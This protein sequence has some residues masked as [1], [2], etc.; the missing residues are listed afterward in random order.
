MTWRTPASLKWLIVQRSRLSGAL[1]QIDNQKRKL[2]KRLD[3]L[4]NRAEALREQLS[5]L[6][7]TFGLH[8]IRVDPKC[9]QPV[10]PQ[11]KERL[12]PPGRLGRVI[13]AELRRADDWLSSTE[14]LARIANHITADGLTYFEVRHRLRRRLGRLGRDGILERQVRY[15]GNGANDD[16]LWRIA[17]A[18]K[19]LASGM[20]VNG[21]VSVRAEV[22]AGDDQVEGPS[23]SK[24]E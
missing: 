3:D 9:I 1:A 20:A 19:E 7:Q 5:A 2:L 21:L 22:A 4:D 18:T 15:C 8:T 12:M 13:L 24:V 14:I 10:R 6:D 16:T 23:R 17:P 11:G